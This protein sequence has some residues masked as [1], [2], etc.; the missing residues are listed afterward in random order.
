MMCWLLRSHP[1]LNLFS[2][3]H[4]YIMLSHFFFFFQAEDGIRDDLVTG[5]Q[6]CALPICH[7]VLPPR[8]ARLRLPRPP[9]PARRPAPD[10]PARQKALAVPPA[11]LPAR[12]SRPGSAAAPRPA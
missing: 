4:V 12:L 1:H 6:T 10:D 8:L 9:T 7:L 3:S 5:V 2:Q 11:P